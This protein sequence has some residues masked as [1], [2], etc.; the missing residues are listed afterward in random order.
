VR[1]VPLGWKIDGRKTEMRAAE[2]TLKELVLHVSPPRGCAIVLT[3]LK[4]SGP[5]DPNWVAAC[6]IM[7]AQ[8][9]SRFN[10]KV[11]ELRRTDPQVDWSDVQISVGGDRRV[12]HWLWEVEGQ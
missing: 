6:G 1:F 5:T 7:K 12:A 3:E 4:S 2:A 10:E 11:V 9:L 8:W